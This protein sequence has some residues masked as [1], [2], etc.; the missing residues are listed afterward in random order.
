MT[1]SA[2]IVGCS[3]S[4]LSVHTLEFMAMLDQRIQDQTTHLNDKYE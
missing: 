3:Q 4:I 1:Y 2:S